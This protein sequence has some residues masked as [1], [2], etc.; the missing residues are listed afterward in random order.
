MTGRNSAK[1]GYIGQFIVN[2]FPQLDLERR[3][4]QLLAST[5]ASRITFTQRA[6][7]AMFDT[8]LHTDALYVQDQWTVRPADAVGRDPVRSHG[9]LLPRAADRSRT[10]CI[11]S[12]R[13]DPGAGWHLVYR[14]HAPHGCGLRRLRRRKDGPEGQLGKYLAAA[15]GSSI[16]GS[17][18][19]PLEPHHALQRRT[20]NWIDAN[21]NYRV[22]CDLTEHGGAGPARLGWR[23]C[24]AGNGELRPDAAITTTYDPEILN[25][26]G[27]RP[28]DW[29]FGVQVQQ[30]LLPRVSVDVGYFRRSFGNFFVTDNRAFAPGDFDRRQLAAPSDARFPAA[31]ATSIGGLYNVDP[32]SSDSTDNFFIRCGQL[33]QADGAMER[34]RDQFHRACA[35]RTHAA[36]RHQHGPNDH[37]QLRHPGGNCRR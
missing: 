37:R 31:A 34:H 23:L 6:G 7:P 5:T 13:G 14:H 35:Q 22:D 12:A 36:G 30:Q 29:N 17:L 2:H 16:T 11:P 3:V 27:I 1:I 9:G 33:R 4:D 8:Q 10:R 26:W 21:N 19:N 24:G 32:R 15:D 20:G 25:G 28:Y 18:T